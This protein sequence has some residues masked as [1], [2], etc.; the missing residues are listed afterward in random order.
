MGVILITTNKCL[1][2][3]NAT[4]EALGQGKQ[5]ILIRSY[6]T[7]LEGFLL[8]PSVSYAREDS[9][10]EGFQSKYQGF[11]EK[12]ALPIK[13][14]DKFPI[15]YYVSVEKIVEMSPSAIGGL[16]NKYIWT[17]EH[18]RNYLKGKNA[19]IWVLRVYKLKKQ[20]FDKPIKGVIKYANLKEE[21]SLEGMEPVLSDSEFSKISEKL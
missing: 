7:S 18:V 12:N 4:I 1:K 13:K 6:R 10:L 17:S 9:Y 14:D 8:Y 3:W 19:Q 15:K 5:T 2:E 11:V 21:V 20:Y 16:K